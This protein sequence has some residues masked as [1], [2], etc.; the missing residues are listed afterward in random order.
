MA[1]PRYTWM[2]KP[3]DLQPD[4]P[5]PELTPAEKRKNFWY[6][7][8]WYFLIGAVVLFFVVYT[9][10]DIVTQVRPDYQ[11][12]LITTIGYPNNTETVLAEQ[13]APFFDDRNGDGQVVVTVNIFSIA[14]PQTASTIDPNMQMANQTKLVGDISTGESMIFLV[15]N[16]A[17]LNAQ[18][19]LFP[20][21]DGT[22]PVPYE[23]DEDDLVNETLTYD[24]ADNERV[25]VRWGDCP[26]LTAL[27]LG[28]SEEPL[29]APGYSYQ[30]F[31]EDFR[32]TMRLFKNTKLE[33][34]E[35]AAAYYEASAAALRRMTER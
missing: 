6:Y 21:N 4:A 31:L 18:Y 1:S 9:I 13:L 24:P 27:E 11:I 32:L 20:Y 28:E 26:K 19:G 10:V 33:S 17:L 22:E 8:K 16:P 35:D 14:G 2:L 29:D 34:D 25:G 23:S 5:P 12:G 7:N 30:L 3:E 15:D